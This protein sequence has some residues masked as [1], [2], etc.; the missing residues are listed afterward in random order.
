MNLKT[1]AFGLFAGSILALSL[2]TGVMAQDTS[3]TLADG[4]GC[5]ATMIASAINFGSWTW[6]GDSY[7]NSTVASGSLAVDVTN[8]VQAVTTCDVSMT[9]NGLTGANTLDTIAAVDVL[10]TGATNNTYTV[11]Q[12]TQLTVAAT[13]ATDLNT[14]AP[15]TYT[16]TIT[17][18]T[19]NAGA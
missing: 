13:L 19:V 1:K 6:D 2:T 8:A 4:D 10:L 16:G 11:P 15:D 18:G 3:V 14:L 12:N 17:V 5:A 9:V 7:V